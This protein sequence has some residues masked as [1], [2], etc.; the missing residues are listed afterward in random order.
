M[1]RPQSEIGWLM[2]QWLGVLVPGAFR[3]E[4]KTCGGRRPGK[5]AT[6]A[7]ARAYVIG[8]DKDPRST[9]ARRDLPVR[10]E[11]FDVDRRVEE[12]D[13]ARFTAGDV[14]TWPSVEAMLSGEPPEGYEP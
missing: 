9:K 12:A 13:T 8:V 7:A 1:M 5:A 2:L 10:S 3:E 11:I 14:L 6:A 4:V